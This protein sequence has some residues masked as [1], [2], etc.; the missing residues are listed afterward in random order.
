M[1][2][3]FDQAHST[4][5]GFAL[6]KFDDQKSLQ[7]RLLIHFF[8]SHP[9]NNVGIQNYRNFF[10]SSDRGEHWQVVESL[11]TYGSFGSVC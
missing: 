9:Q 4:V 7:I 6:L 8:H 5:N 3:D 1:L 2:L 11:P 10:I